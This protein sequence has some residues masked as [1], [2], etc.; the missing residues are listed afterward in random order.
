MGMSKSQFEFPKISGIILF[1]TETEVMSNFIHFSFSI[2]IAIAVLQDEI[3]FLFCICFI[4]LG[5]CFARIFGAFSEPSL[6]VRL[7]VWMLITIKTLSS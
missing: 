3:F 4:S 1:I 6:S 7:K 5:F 2:H